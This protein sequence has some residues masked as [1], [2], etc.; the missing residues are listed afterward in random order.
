MKIKGSSFFHLLVTI[1]LVYTIY[2]WYSTLGTTGKEITEVIV[3]IVGLIYCVAHALFMRDFFDCVIP[4]PG[5]GFMLK[6]EVS[7]MFRFSPFHFVIHLLYN[8]VC[9]PIVFIS[10]WCDKHLSL[11]DED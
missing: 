11:G 5:D 9:Q 4:D 1:I 7:D 2:S 8:F 6:G 3:F 10:R